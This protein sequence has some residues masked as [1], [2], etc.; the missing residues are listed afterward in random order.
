MQEKVAHLFPAF[1]LKYTGKE[2]SII[3]KH[4]FNFQNRLNQSSKILG[5]NLNEF[6]IKNCNL[7]EDELKNQM[8]SYIFSCTFSDILKRK[9]LTPNFVSGFSMGLYAALYHSNA[10]DFK[11]GLFLI[12]DV[13]QEIKNLMGTKKH[14]MAS[15]V[16]FYDD[17]L[18]TFMNSFNNI[19]II[20]QNGIYSFVI[21]GEEEAEINDLLEILLNEGAIHLNI[22]NINFPYH[23]KK[24]KENHPIFESIANNYVVNNAKVPLVSMID[25]G[26]LNYK[27]EIKAEI[28]KNITH[29]LNFYKTIHAL[30]KQGV[31]EFI[32]IGADSSLL[33]SSIFIEGD[34]EFKAVAKG[35]VV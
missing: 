31:N 33:K 6:D 23:S 10:I 21:A 4:G 20:I 35:K 12:R 13:F 18:K 24:L 17:E 22:F 2:L 19:E 3:E 8:M 14:T 25:Q 9:N 16:G 26:Q 30:N 11:T 34:F 15:V 1:V 28:A 29:P 5:L 32:E 7:I 27:E